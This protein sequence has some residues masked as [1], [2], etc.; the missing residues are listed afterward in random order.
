MAAATSPWKTSPW[1]AASADADVSEPIVSFAEIMSEELAAKLQCEEETGYVDEIASPSSVAD[2]DLPLTLS[3]PDA[4][5]SDDM[6][7][8]RLLQHEFDKEHDEMLRRT[9]AKYNGNDKVSVSF[10]K[11]LHTHPLEESS[12][13]EEDEELREMMT[14]KGYNKGNPDFGASGFVRDADGKIITKHDKDVCGRKNTAKALQFPPDFPMG[15]ACDIK[16]NNQVYNVLK[17]HSQ[18]E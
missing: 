2:A 9:E 11:Y 18:T 1:G 14:H 10:G 15:D 5:C 3:S 16:L 6:L 12:S 8:A 4:D 17:K 7:M 13:S